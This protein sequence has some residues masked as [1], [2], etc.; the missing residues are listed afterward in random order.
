[1]TLNEVIEEIKKQTDDFD[2]VVLLSDGYGW[3]NIS[4]IKVT[5]SAIE[6][7]HDRNEIFS[8]DKI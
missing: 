4:S 5:E 6:L 7:H 2:K 8:D 3:T 1:M